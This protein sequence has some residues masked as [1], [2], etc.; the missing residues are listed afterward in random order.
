MP[1]E[2]HPYE[3]LP[4]PSYEEATSSRPPSSQ[5]VSNDD[6]ERQ[7]LL[8][9]DSG[10]S[11]QPSRRENRP[12]LFSRWGDNE[13]GN[14]RPPMAQSVA[15]SDDDGLS[16]PSFDSDNT[17]DDDEALRQDIE[18]ME[19][20]EPGSLDSGSR[21]STRSRLSKRFSSITTTLSSLHLPTFAFPRPS[22]VWLTRRMPTWPEQYRPGFAIVARLFGLFVIISL[23]YA[24]F[25]MEIIPG[26]RVGFGQPFN[27]EWVR[28]FA[29]SSIDRG[30]IADNLKMITKF[31]HVAGTEGDWSH[32]KTIEKIFTSIGLDY[33]GVLE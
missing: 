13:R 16:L 23:V 24:L 20:L 5:A 25:V 12:G 2:K 8:H 7:G 19:M 28:Q 18:Q 29:Q 21:S 31:D 27:P 14:Y 1:G 4:I 9:P 3:H 10:N 22:F 6:A 17:E 26:G 11:N 30:R 33:V 15:D 32:A